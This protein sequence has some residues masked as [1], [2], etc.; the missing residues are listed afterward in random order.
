MESNNQEKFYSW[1]DV[2]EECVYRYPDIKDD[3]IENRMKR[4]VRLLTEEQKKELKVGRKYF[5][6]EIE[7]EAIFFFVSEMRDSYLSAVLDNR[8]TG[9]TIEESN[10]KA[11]N[12]HKKMLE[13]IKT[14]ENERLQELLT[15]LIEIICVS[16]LDNIRNEIIANIKQIGDYI[17]RQPYGKKVEILAVISDGIKKWMD[18]KGIQ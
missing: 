11:R 5:F 7:K 17:E 18:N 3:L 16:E 13:K 2:L 14:I 10:K 9:K 15:H 8:S 4:L 6:S 1:D 12:F